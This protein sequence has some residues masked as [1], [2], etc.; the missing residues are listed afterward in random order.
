M[1]RTIIAFLAAPLWIPFIFAIYAAF[2]SKPPDFFG[3]PDQFMWV[4]RSV[5]VGLIVGYV[6]AF[7]FG[8]PAHLFLRARQSGF[9]AYVL[10]WLLIG[11]VFWFLGSLCMGLIV[12]KELDFTLREVVDTLLSRPR[13]PLSACILG[14]LVGATIWRLTRP[15]L[16]QR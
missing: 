16:I 3:E 12:T 7:L 15:N 5:I 1:A 13:V 10:I 11:F 8:L 4:V 6:P 9:L 14:L 2:F